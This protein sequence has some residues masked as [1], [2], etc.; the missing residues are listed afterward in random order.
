ME[1][2]FVDRWFAERQHTGRFGYA[3]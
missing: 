1:S 2:W 3:L